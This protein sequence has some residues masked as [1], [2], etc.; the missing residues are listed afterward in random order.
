MPAYLRA[1]FIRE[2][3]IGALSYKE[4]R[5]PS[6]VFSKIMLIHSIYFSI[7]VRFFNSCE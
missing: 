3:A 1:F 5:R 7:M 2:S 6:L 4:K